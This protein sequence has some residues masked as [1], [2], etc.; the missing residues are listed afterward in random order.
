ML[1]TQISYLPSST[2]RNLIKL[3]HTPL[4]RESWGMSAKHVKLLS[5]SCMPYSWELASISSLQYWSVVDQRWKEHSNVCLV[6]T[7]ALKK[8]DPADFQA[9]LKEGG[10]PLLTEDQLKYLGK[11]KA[12]AVTSLCQ[13]IFKAEK[14]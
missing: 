5:V 11:A 6:N 3:I 1:T 4:I 12:H 7:L 14:R 8:C 2:V 10:L 13:G 9:M